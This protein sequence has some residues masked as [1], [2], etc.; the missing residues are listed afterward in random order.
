MNWNTNVMAA[1]VEWGVKR[2]DHG[3]ASTRSLLKINIFRSLSF[4]F[5]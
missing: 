3:E 2:V 5:L 4:S 1:A